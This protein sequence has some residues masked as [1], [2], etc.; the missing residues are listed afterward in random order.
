MNARPNCADVEP[1]LF[2]TDY[3]TAEAIQELTDTA[4][5]YCAS[6]PVLADCAA[7]ADRSRMTGLFGGA[8]RTDERNPKGWEKSER[9]GCTDYAWL[10]LIPEAP[11][12]DPMAMQP[13]Q[14]GRWAA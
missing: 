11:E 8:L 3:Y 12:P 1:E 7:R 5:E 6:C 9:K 13:W 14:K 4:R 10:R 2:F